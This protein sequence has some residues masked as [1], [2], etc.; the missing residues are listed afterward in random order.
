MNKTLFL[1]AGCL[2]ALTSPLLA[3][4]TGCGNPGDNNSEEDDDN[5]ETTAG[6]NVGT[7]PVNP[8][9]A[10]LIRRVTDL[11]TYGAAPIEFTRI[12]RQINLQRSAPSSCSVTP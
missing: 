3:Y 5:C 9:R 8:Y 10:C 1:L 2:L 6:N 11:Q 4:D 7:N 12:L